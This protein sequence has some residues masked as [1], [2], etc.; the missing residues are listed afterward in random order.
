[1]FVA[2]A[3]E[4]GNDDQKHNI[5]NLLLQYG[6]KKILKNIYES[7]TIN[8]NQL[9]RLKREIDRLTDS[10]DILRFYQYPM[11]E[12]LV[13]SSLKEKKWRKMIIRI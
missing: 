13:L 6:F 3:C 7:A 9:L 10:Y 11:D 2:I 4:L 1:M 8:S 12:T 5:Y